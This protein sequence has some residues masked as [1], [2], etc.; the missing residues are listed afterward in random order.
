MLVTIL[1]W[2]VAISTMI[3]WIYNGFRRPRNLTRLLYQSVIWLQRQEIL[4][5][6][7]HST[8]FDGHWH[9][10][11]EDVMV[12]ACTSSQILQSLV[13]RA[14]LVVGISSQFVT[15][16]Y[17][18]CGISVIDSAIIFT[19]FLFSVSNETTPILITCLMDNKW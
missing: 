19:E 7:H 17:Y 14:N 13:T 5:V 16:F 9:C 2:S 1:S 6:S 15:L 8:I 18:K 3:V 12:L 4:K 10:G 11:R